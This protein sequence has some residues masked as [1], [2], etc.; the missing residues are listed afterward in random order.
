MF[1]HHLLTAFRHLR[2]QKGYS[3]INIIGL[4]VGMA[5]VILIGLYIQDELS[6][7]RYHANAGRLYRLTTC[8]V[9]AS[10]P[11]FVGTPAPLAQ[12][13]KDQFPEVEDFVRFDPFMGRSKALFQHADRSFYE[14]RFFLADPSL[15]RVFSFQLLRG[16]SAIALSKPNYIV[17]SVMGSILIVLLAISVSVVVKLVS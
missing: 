4:A 1:K 6:Y 8:P 16:D 10:L 17:I 7:D 15:F 9:E 5:C 2:R 3:L 12:A 14:D 13:L 11:D